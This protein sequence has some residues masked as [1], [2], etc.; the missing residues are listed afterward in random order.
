M[1]TFFPTLYRL[2]LGSAVLLATACG[3]SGGGTSPEPEPTPPASSSSTSSQNSSSGDDCPAQQVGT[4]STRIEGEQ[5]SCDDTLPFVSDAQFSGGEAL[6]PADGDTAEYTLHIETSGLFTLSYRAGA[7]DNEALWNASINGTPLAVEPVSMAPSESAQTV[8]TAAFYLSDGQQTLQVHFEQAPA[9]LDYMELQYTEALRH[10]PHDAV[11]SMGIGINLGNTLD[12]Y[13]NE[14]DWAPKAQEPFFVAF[15]EAGFHHVRIPAT[16]DT[17]VS[18]TAPYTVNE[19]RMTR[20][21]QIVDW[22]LAQGYYVILNAHH[23][24]WLKENYDNPT[25]RARFDAIWTQIAERFAH[26]SARLMF[27][28]LNEPVGMSMAQVNDLNPRILDIIRAQNPD[29]LVIISSNDYTP[30]YG[31]SGITVP[32]DDYLI[33]NFHSYDPWTFAGQC[34]ERW[35]STADKNELEGLYQIASDWS[36]NSG[37]PVM[38]NEFGVPHYDHLNPENECHQSD[39]LDYLS[40]HV[41]FATQYGVAATVWDDAGSF[42]IYNRADGTWG[43]EKDILVAPNP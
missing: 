30:V 10:D 1:N 8:T 26:K 9:T 35:G 28:I 14:G 4:S 24:T 12:A 13:P 31:L 18:D 41:N 32:D 11:T 42:G 5:L 15:N 39:R 6:A 20:T 2:C 25:T 21:E 3:S 19:D 16:W 22:A 34:I 23:E 37:I 36:E 38:V 43:P 33:G 27:E 40:T 7:N 17:H 29:R